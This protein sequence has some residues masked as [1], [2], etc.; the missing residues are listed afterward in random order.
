M[1]SAALPTTL[2][3]RLAR[4]GLTIVAVYALVALLTP[5]LLHH[6]DRRAWVLRPPRSP[7]G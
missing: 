7:P 6:S 4:W 5:L 2:S 3:G 1:L